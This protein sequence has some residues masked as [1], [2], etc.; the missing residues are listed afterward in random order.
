[1]AVN[2]GSRV[3]TGRGTQVVET[4]VVEP[5]VEP[6]SNRRQRASDGVVADPNHRNVAGGGVGHLD[7]AA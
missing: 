3:N 6:E 1:M 7:G 5:R 2:N 4:Q